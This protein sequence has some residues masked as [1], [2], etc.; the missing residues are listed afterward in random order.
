MN[1]L[2]H[3]RKKITYTLHKYQVVY[4]VMKESERRDSLIIIFDHQT[5]SSKLKNI[6]NEFKNQKL[7]YQCS[8]CPE[9]WELTLTIFK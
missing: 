3:L 8:F 4:A 6:I 7:N 1:P 9:T 2:T 5:Q